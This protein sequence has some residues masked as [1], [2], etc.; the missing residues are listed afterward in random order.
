MHDDTCALQ[1]LKHA[2]NYFAGHGRWTMRD[3]KDSRGSR[4]PQSLTPRS[5]LLFRF[6]FAGRARQRSPLGQTTF[7]SFWMQ[8]TTGGIG[9]SGKLVFQLVTPTSPT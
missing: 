1:L 7:S 3:D 4:S 9:V 2:H 5:R 6:D 8:R